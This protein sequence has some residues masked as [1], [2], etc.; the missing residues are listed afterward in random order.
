MSERWGDQKWFPP[1]LWP[2]TDSSACLCMFRCWNGSWEKSKCAEGRHVGGVVL[3]LK[4]G[5]STLQNAPE[6]LWKIHFWERSEWKQREAQ[7]K[8]KLMCFCF[9]L[10]LYVTGLC[11]QCH[12]L[13]DFFWYSVLDCCWLLASFL[14]PFLL[15]QFNVS[16]ALVVATVPTFADKK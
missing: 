7:C 5:L 16:S 14:S 3:D 15:K 6:T 1:F 10:Y 12:C 11:G 4:P 8:K 13:F 9:I 2:P